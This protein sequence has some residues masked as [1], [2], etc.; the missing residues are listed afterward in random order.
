MQGTV[1]LSEVWEVVGMLD[2]S[3]WRTRDGVQEKMDWYRIL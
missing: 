2:K 3:N 1:I